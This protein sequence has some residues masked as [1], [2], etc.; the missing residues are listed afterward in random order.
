LK[1]PRFLIVT[2][3]TLLV[4]SLIRTAWLSDDAYITF[5]TADNVIHGYG[6]VWNTAERV[7][8]YTH[9]LWLALITPAFAATGE[10]YYTAIVL[11]MLVTL[12]AVAVL[13]RRLAATPWNLV[14][15]L[16][17]LLS[18][19]AFIDFTSGSRIR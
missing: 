2:G 15:C 7:Q 5:R 17:A 18:S 12:A 3:M 10:V 1:S 19:K 14:V 11:S 9:P 4:I 13:A 16:A 8:T 6:L